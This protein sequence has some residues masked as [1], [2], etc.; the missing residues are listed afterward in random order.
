MA[1]VVEEESM[2]GE[3]RDSMKLREEKDEE[4]R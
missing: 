3:D 2:E 4:Q 1:E